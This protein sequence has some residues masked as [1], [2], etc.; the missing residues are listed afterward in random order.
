[1]QS[2][3]AETSYGRLHALAGGTAPPVVILVPGLVIASEYMAPTGKILAEFCRVYAVDLPGYG[4]SVKPR[5]VLALAELADALAE[6]M[7]ASGIQRAHF[8]G[9]SF[10]CQILAWLAV[11]HPKRVDRL[12]LQG[13]TVDPE[14]RSL[15]RQLLRLIRNSRLESPD[16]GRITRRDYRRAGLRRAWATL[17]LALRDRIEDR[18]PLVLAPCLVVRGDR[19]PLVPQRWAERVARLLPRGELVVVPGASHTMNYVAPDALVAA[20]RPFLGL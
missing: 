5:K 19:D 17:R 20:M 14:A 13:P 11:R 2:V 9:N 7:D 16:L 8:F 15:M 4:L 10:G 6:W 18:L 12:V 3:W 1:M